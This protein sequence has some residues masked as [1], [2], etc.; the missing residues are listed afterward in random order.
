MDEDILRQLLTAQENGLEFAPTAD[1]MMM[2]SASMNDSDGF[3]PALMA[4]MQQ[5]QQAVRVNQ[6]A[7]SSRDIDTDDDL[8]LE[9]ETILERIVALKEMFPESVQKAFGTLNSTVVNTSKFALSKGRTAAW[10]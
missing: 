8:F 7:M 6:Q 9:D 2:D 1:M 3:D 5:H 10:W 4:M